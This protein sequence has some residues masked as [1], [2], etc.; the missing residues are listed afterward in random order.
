MNVYHTIEDVYTRRKEILFLNREKDK[1]WPVLGMIFI[2]FFQI[3][4]FSISIDFP[5][6]TEIQFH[7]HHNIIFFSPLLS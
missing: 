7:Y 2:F 5:F 6:N 3:N 4:G 1:M